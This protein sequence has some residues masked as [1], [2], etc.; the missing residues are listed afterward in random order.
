[1]IAEAINLKET[2]VPNPC[3]PLPDNYHARLGLKLDPEK[4]KVYDQ[5]IKIEEYA[6]I[7][8]IYGFQSHKQL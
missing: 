1:M 5:I 2:I 7:N 6:N 4:S 3:R 8:E